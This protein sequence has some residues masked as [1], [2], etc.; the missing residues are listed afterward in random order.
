MDVSMEHPH[1]D[2]K[3]A[4]ALEQVCCTYAAPS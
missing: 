3:L 1:Q 4:C 2:P